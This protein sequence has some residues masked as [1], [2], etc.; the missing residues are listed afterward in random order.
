MGEAAVPPE[1]GESWGRPRSTPA[2]LAPLPPC[3]CSSPVAGE[4]P[5]VPGG[6]TRPHWQLGH[7]GWQKAPHGVGYLRARH[8]P[9]GAQHPCWHLSL[10]RCEEG[11][12]KGGITRVGMGAEGPLDLSSNRAE[13]APQTVL[14]FPHHGWGKKKWTERCIPE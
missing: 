8:L 12:P 7:S 6:L 13:C 10:S 2:P 11:V 3:G 5:E 4:E 9:G 1:L 14:G